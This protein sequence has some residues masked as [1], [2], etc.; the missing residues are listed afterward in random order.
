[1]AVS[2]ALQLIKCGSSKW[3]H[4]TISEPTRG[5]RGQEEYGAFS[6]SVSPIGQTIE[7]IQGQERIIAR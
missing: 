6:V 2:Q 3:I 5:L 4:E 1:M 7:Y